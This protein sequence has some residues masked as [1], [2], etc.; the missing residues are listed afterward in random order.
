MLFL[1]GIWARENE[2]NLIQGSQGSSGSQECAWVR[3]ENCDEFENHFDP[4]PIVIFNYLIEGK[5]GQKSVKVN[6]SKLFV[7]GIDCLK[8]DSFATPNE[9][10]N[11]SDPVEVIIDNKITSIEN[12]N[13]LKG[14]FEPMHLHFGF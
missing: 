13:D 11:R 12:I 7:E 10:L 14:V 3:H 5:P 2:S 6:K 4:G 9:A 1:G 8:Y